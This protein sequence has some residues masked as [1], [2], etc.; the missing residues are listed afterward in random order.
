MTYFYHFENSLHIK[1]QLVDTVYRVKDLYTI[2]PYLVFNMG[3]LKL[4][5][6]IRGDI[7]KMHQMSPYCIIVGDVNETKDYI[8]SE[9]GY[10]N[11]DYAL[12]YDKEKQKFDVIDIKAE[13]NPFFGMENNI[14]AGF[15]KFW[16][17]YMN[18]SGEAVS[19]YSAPDLLSYIEK[20]SK[21]SGI[22]K[23][24]EEIAENVI[25]DDNHIIVIAK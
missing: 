5:Q 25:E 8:F 6:D 2:S 24:L 7:N 4:P 21:K 9:F 14:I 12:L 10:K 11:K 23:Q 18:S 13:N 3:N 15:P 1:E 19:Y 22:S 17:K 20:E 16:P